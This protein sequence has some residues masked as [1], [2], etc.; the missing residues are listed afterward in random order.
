M[1]IL[2]FV[3]QRYKMLSKVNQHEKIIQATV[4]RVISPEG[5]VAGSIFT[6]C[7]QISSVNDGLMS[8]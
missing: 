8:L 1:Q 6:F 5:Q 4:T 3:A 7:L 2:F